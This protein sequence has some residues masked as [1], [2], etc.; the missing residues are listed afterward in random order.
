MDRMCA[1]PHQTGMVVTD[2]ERHTRKTHLRIRH[3]AVWVLKL[4]SFSVKEEQGV[5]YLGDRN[6]AHSVRPYRCERQI[7]P[8]AELRLPEETTDIAGA[9]VLPLPVGMLRKESR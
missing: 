8:H 7:R 6:A 9:Y 2:W 4:P 1:V 3:S 5:Y